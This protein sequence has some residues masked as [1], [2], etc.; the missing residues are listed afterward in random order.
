MPYD[1]APAL[2]ASDQRNTRTCTDLFYVDP[3]G[4]STE[5]IRP[6]KDRGRCFFAYEDRSSAE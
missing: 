2:L 3:L 1:G 6:T 4:A 5:R